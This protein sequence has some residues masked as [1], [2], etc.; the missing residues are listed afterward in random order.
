MPEIDADAAIAKNAQQLEV[1]DEEFKVTFRGQLWTSTNPFDWPMDWVERINR[2]EVP[3]VLRMAFGD[4]QYE[5]LAALKP[6]V[7]LVEAYG[8]VAAIQEAIGND[9]G[10]R[11]RSGRSSATTPN[12][13]KR[14]SRRTTKSISSI[15]GGDDSVSE[16]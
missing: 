11:R 15:T 3:S 8:L 4:D 7:K 14:T 16:S 12:I 5:D 10:K 2:G 9:L 13:S 6:P 1:S